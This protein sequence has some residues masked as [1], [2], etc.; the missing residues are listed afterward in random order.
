MHHYLAQFRITRTSTRTRGI[1]LSDSGTG[2][3]GLA[4]A[5]ESGVQAGIQDVQGLRTK[6]T[7]KH[8]LNGRTCLTRMQKPSESHQQ[9]YSYS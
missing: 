2:D 4:A 6:L 5:D 8:G 1:T 7:T 9:Q 3:V